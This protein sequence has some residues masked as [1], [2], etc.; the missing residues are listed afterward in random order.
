MRRSERLLRAAAVA[1]LS[2]GIALAM[3][4]AGGGTIPATP[5]VVVPLVLAFA[6]STQ[7]AGK[8]MSR[9]RLATAVVTA[10]AL[11]H[12]A[13]AWGPGAHVVAL[14]AG[15]HASHQ[16]TRLA[17]DSASV[18][19]AHATVG[20]SMLAAHAAAAVATYALLRRADVFV[21]LLR[22]AAGSLAARLTIAPPRLATPARLAA[23]PGHTPVSIS[24]ARSPRGLR[25]PPLHLA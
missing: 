19:T 6:V 21:A 2:T 1:C 11:F 23:Q 7:L 22:R 12:G 18:H 24:I 14:G 15:P 3:H 8:P 10:Q 13:F 20:P 4:I 17:V 9:W 16:L 5:G 25:G